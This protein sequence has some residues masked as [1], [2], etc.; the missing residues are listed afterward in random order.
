MALAET[1]TR[2]ATVEDRGGRAG[3]AGHIEAVACRYSG[4]GRPAVGWDDAKPRREAATASYRKYDTIMT[5]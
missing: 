5:L 4:C 3:A 1:L 2:I